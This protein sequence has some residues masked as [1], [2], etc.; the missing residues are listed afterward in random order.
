MILLSYKIE[1]ISD[2]IIK[3]NVKGNSYEYIV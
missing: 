1:D 2:I 3:N